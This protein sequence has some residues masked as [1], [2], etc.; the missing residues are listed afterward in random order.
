LSNSSHMVCCL[1][2]LLASSFDTLFHA[3]FVL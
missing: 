2:I 3:T 1:K